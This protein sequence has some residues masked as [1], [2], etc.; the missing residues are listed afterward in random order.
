ME[1]F[2]EAGRIR[3]W[4][5]KSFFQSENIPQAVEHYLAASKFFTVD[6]M[7]MPAIS[8]LR[9]AAEMLCKVRKYVNAAELYAEI[10]KKE[11]E[12][13]SIELQACESF[14]ISILLFLAHG[15][16]G[17]L[18]MIKERL[19]SFTEAD[20]LFRNSPQNDFVQKLMESKDTQTFSFHVYEYC[21]L[22]DVDVLT[23]DIMDVI[24]QQIQPN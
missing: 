17:D 13:H 15:S 21:F 4:K 1:K 12:G 11:L 7:P 16:C 5:A 6:K 14:F 22:H 2:S 10:G 9:H 24:Q 18:P 19:R 8:C 3:T 20:I 23:L